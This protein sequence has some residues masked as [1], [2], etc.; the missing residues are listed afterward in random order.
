[1]GQTKS[2]MTV[3][4]KRKEKLEK[5]CVKTQLEKSKV[6]TEFDQVGVDIKSSRD[7]IEA[8]SAAAV[9]DEKTLLS[10]KEELDRCKT[11]AE[12]Q[13]SQ[14]QVLASQTKDLRDKIKK[15]EGLLRKER[16]KVEEQNMMLEEK[17]RKGKS[18]ES[19]TEAECRQLEQT[20]CKARQYLDESQRQK[21]QLV[22]N[23]DKEES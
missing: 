11:E 10:G 18:V 22:E 9:A 1:M 16:S 19:T 5:Q 23:L 8:L 2:E 3:V 14:S 7:G 15:V 4:A 13:A 20:L 21:N 12:Q 6:K 17:Q